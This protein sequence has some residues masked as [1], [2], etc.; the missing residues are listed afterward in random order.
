M[1]FS[2]ELCGLFD[3]HTISILYDYFNIRTILVT[4]RQICSNSNGEITLM[5][6]LVNI[7]NV[8][9]YNNLLFILTTHI[10]VHDPNTFKLLDI[11]V[12]SSG[13]ENMIIQ[14]NILAYNVGK[15]IKLYHFKT[16]N[17]YQIS[18][19][20]DVTKISI[21]NHMIFYADSLGIV[22]M[23]NMRN[24]NTRVIL[25]RCGMNIIDMLFKIDEITKLQLLFILDS[26]GYVVMVVL[27]GENYGMQV[28]WKV[29]DVALSADKL[30]YFKNKLL[31]ISGQ[32]L[33]VWDIETQLLLKQ[34]KIGRIVYSTTHYDNIYIIVDVDDTRLMKIYSVNDFKHLSN[35]KIEKDTNLVAFY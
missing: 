14:N 8:I 13:A 3:L 25:K 30:M 19:C 26:A 2:Y 34:T 27:S 24:K 35:T 29:T 15:I 18:N 17:K 28:S 11:I 4:T 12:E 5:M 23:L 1:N 7:K 6:D 31:T 9:Y 22:Y 20:A 10:H 32:Y 16:E 21:F 33:K